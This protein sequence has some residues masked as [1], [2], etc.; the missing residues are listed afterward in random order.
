MR[1]IE[2]HIYRLLRRL[3]GHLCRN[4]FALEIVL[5]FGN[6]CGKAVRIALNIRQV[7]Y[8]SLSSDTHTHAHI[9]HMLMGEKGWKRQH[10]RRACTSPEQAWKLIDCV[11]RLSFR[12]AMNWLCCCD[13]IPAMMTIL[14]S[15]FYICRCCCS[16]IWILY[17]VIH[18]DFKIV[19]KH[20]SHGGL[21][22]R[23]S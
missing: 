14:L 11:V 19:K 9:S 16:I 7:S 1:A 2:S 10:D 5:R 18:R 3:S 21:S 4:L 15:F 13:V 23:P 20:H 12:V 8:D 22:V 6:V 17:N